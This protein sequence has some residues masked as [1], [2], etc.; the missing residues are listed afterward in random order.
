[1]CS[2]QVPWV[3]NCECEG[4]D[5]NFRWLLR[6]TDFLGFVAEPLAVTR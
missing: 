2:R 3:R 4:P 5:E 6:V 1:M